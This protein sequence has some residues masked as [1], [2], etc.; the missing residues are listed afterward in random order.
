MT[1]SPSLLL[2]YR[3]GC[4]LCEDLASLIYRGWPSLADRL[5]W[6]DVDTRPEWRHSYGLRVPVLVSED[7][8]LG[9]LVADKRCLTEHFG[10]PDN[11][12]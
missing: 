5:T 7:R 10:P 3:E 6:L 12:L 1:E 2:Y 4:H 9:E 8:V 11:P